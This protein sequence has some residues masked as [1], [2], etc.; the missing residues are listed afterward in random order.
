MVHRPRSSIRSADAG[1]PVSGWLP[2]HGR[3]GPANQ[4][5]PA[6][7][8]TEML[9]AVTIV[10]ILGYVLLPAVDSISA[11]R[12]DS[13]AHILSADMNLARSLALQYN[14]QWS[15]RFDT[16]N[17]GY[18][19]VW[20]GT[21]TPSPVPDNP[22]AIGPPTPGVFHVDIGKLGMST[23]GSNGVIFAGAAL[24]TSRTNVPDVTF[25]PLGSTGPTRSDDTVVWFTWG[26]GTQT[27]FS[28][29]TVSWVTGQVWVDPPTMF[30]SVNQLFQ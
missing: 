15:I 20:T 13:V 22:H 6:F 16:K 30:T 7:T 29:L 26:Q 8:L 21:G 19:L 3:I 5:F 17:N 27:M 11:Q 28:R 9:M 12:M 23:A 2:S 10:A 24:K 1:S 4:R 25:G 18:N 14:T